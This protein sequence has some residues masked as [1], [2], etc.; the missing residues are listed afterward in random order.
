MPINS[1]QK[2]KRGELEARDEVRRLWGCLGCIRS[3]QAGGAFAADLLHG[4]PL[5]HLEVKLHKK[6]AALKHLRQAERDKSEEEIPIV[7]MRES[8]DKRWVVMLYME[9]AERFVES[10]NDCI[11]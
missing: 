8:G 4:P 3:A 9:D 10:L 5:T 2:G 6:I 7:L 1:R 11:R